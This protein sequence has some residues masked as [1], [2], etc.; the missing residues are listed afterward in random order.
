[1]P[2]FKPKETLLALPKVMPPNCPDVVPALTE[3]IAAAAVLALIVTE[4][5]F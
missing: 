4:L 3:R 5:P 1:V 2:L